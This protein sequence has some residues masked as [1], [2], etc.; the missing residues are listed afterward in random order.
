MPHNENNSWEDDSSSIDYNSTDDD[1][2]IDYESEISIDYDS[3]DSESS[4]DYDDD[5]IEDLS[6]VLDERI[7]LFKDYLDYSKMAHKSYQFEGVRWCLTNELRNDPP[8]GIRGGFI[9]DEM[10]LGKTIMMIGLC[11]ANYK[12]RTLII[13]PPV[14]MN[15]WYDQILR[16]TGCQAYIF[17]GENKHIEKNELMKADFVIATYH[18]IAIKHSNYKNS[19]LHKIHWSRV[20]MDEGHHLRNS[21]TAKHL[22][23]SLLKADIRWIVTG[24]P[25]QNRKQDFYGLC[26]AICM[27]EDYYTDIN[28]IREIADCFVLRR[29]KKKIGIEMPE[30]VIEKENVKWENTLEKELSEKIHGTLSFSNVKYTIDTQVKCGSALS[31]LLRARQ[32]CILPKL[33][34][35]LVENNNNNASKYKDALKYSSKMNAVV[36]TLVER[37]DNGCGKLVFC[38]YK[39]EIDE[40]ASKLK[41]AGIPK[42]AV[43]DGRTPVSERSKMLSEPNDVLILQIQTACEGLNLQENYSEIYFISPHWNPSIE[44]QAIARCHRFGQKKPVYVKR[45]EMEGFGDKTYNIDNY[46]SNSQKIKKQIMKKMIDEDKGVAEEDTIDDLPDKNICLKKRKKE[47]NNNTDNTK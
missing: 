37:K 15:Q 36:K 6:V 44:A 29:T 21:K 46:V 4:I 3:S 45:F 34:T 25:I 41:E 13:V 24:T 28:N 33:L 22:G 12:P 14:L 23:N 11:Y 42:V 16:T 35:P 38:H 47:N 2:S 18:A 43:F 26:S 30:L 17:H 39:Q 20:I 27:P 10:G 31:T 19:L 9:A 8:R 1:S 5:N 7:Q 32:S 40:L